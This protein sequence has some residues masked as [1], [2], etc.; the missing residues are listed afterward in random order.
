MHLTSVLCHQSPMATFHFVVPGYGA[1]HRSQLGGST[2]GTCE[3][4]DLLVVME[5][6][7]RGRPFVLR[8]AGLIQAKDALFRNLRLAPDEY[9]QHH[10][11]SCW[12]EFSLPGIRTAKLWRLNGLTPDAARYGL[13]DPP[14]GAWTI[15]S[16]D[17]SGPALLKN[18]GGFG[19]WLARLATGTDGAPAD[20]WPAYPWRPRF[21]FHWDWP[22]LVDDLL[23]ITGKKEFASRKRRQRHPIRFLTAADLE[24]EDADALGAWMSFGEIPPPD[25]PGTRDGPDGISF[26]HIRF[27][28]VEE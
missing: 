25:E 17:P 28:P 15:H 2:R 22:K 27:D 21:P 24:L 3:L 11:L 7:L 5:F 20:R 1:T 4:A 14:S 23:D 18:G 10:L 6:R 16:T 13:I 9:K 26:L 19:S 8:Q 12:P